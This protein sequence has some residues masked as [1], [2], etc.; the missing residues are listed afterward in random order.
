MGEFQV[1]KYDYLLISSSLYFI[2]YLFGIYRSFI[3]SLS[4]DP[5]S[6]LNF[7][8]LV[9]ILFSAMMHKYTITY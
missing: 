8:C 9:A 7:D 4:F 2:V 3:R 6:K 1:L 5:L